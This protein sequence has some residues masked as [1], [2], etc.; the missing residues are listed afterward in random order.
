M[1]SLRD[2]LLDPTIHS[3]PT[4][5]LMRVFRNH[6]SKRAPSMTKSLFLHDLARS[7][8]RTLL[9]LTDS[10]NA[11][12]VSR[13]VSSRP[14]RW[15]LCFL[16]SI[17]A[18]RPDKPIVFGSSKHHRKPRTMTNSSSNKQQ[19][20]RCSR[21]IHPSQPPIDHAQ[22]LAPSTSSCEFICSSIEG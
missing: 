19:D 21:L 9:S 15:L 12:K 16:Q 14:E 17:F 18:T 5:R 20:I 10:L 1:A 11:S 2:E 8:V 4:L 7:P 13:A 3:D 6:L 22:H